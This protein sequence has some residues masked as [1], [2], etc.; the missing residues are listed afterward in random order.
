MWAV[1][2]PSTFEQHVQRVQG[3]CQSECRQARCGRGSITLVGVSL[4]AA[5]ITRYISA[6][7][8]QDICASERLPVIRPV[9]H[10][11]CHATRPSCGIRA[12]NECTIYHSAWAVPRRFFGFCQLSASAM[13]LDTLVV[14]FVSLR[15]VA[16]LQPDEKHISHPSGP[17][18]SFLDQAL[19]SARPFGKRC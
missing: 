19:L 2:A 7:L 15:L 8:V 11:K 12:S 3:C 5:R 18:R 10:K 13:V 16:K 6:M 9:M 17:V 1:L 4:R 14:P